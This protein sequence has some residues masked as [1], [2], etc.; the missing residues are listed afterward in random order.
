MLLLN[1]IHFDNLNDLSSIILKCK[2]LFIFYINIMNSYYMPAKTLNA[3]HNYEKHVMS[4]H[5]VSCTLF[6]RQNRISYMTK[7]IT[8]NRNLESVYKD[9]T[10]TWTRIQTL[11]IFVVQINK[12]HGLS[13]FF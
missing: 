13:I 2:L 6:Y 8:C 1:I 9:N 11:L 7:A 12:Q 10:L 3:S 5:Q 4:R